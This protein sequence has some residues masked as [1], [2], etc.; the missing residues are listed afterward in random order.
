MSLTETATPLDTKT[1]ILNAAEKLFGLNG[2]DA[3]SLRDITAEAQVNLAAVNYH[4]QSKESLIDAIIERRIQPINRRRFEMLAAA[5][6]SPRVE[7]IVE[8]FLAPVV[9][10]EVLPA[11]PLIGRVLSNPDQFVERVYK[12]HLL[13]VVE[14]FSEAIG[15]ALP[16]LSAEERFW[17]L[18]FM[19][20]S[21]THVL[22]LSGVL[23]LMSGH[24]V[25][26]H[27]LMGRL[28]NFIAAGLRAPSAFLNTT[29]EEN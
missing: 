4:F 24:P 20:G 25:D 28:V 16:G 8:A 10:L 27:A 14:R 15:K 17:R 2:F 21:M 11:V 5:G 19:A 13:H 23:P 3:T 7:Q 22:A 29:S 26:R 12:K 1:R 18:Q 9:M 6:S